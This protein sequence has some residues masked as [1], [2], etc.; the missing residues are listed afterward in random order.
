MD[1]QL[2]DVNIMINL[3]WLFARCRLTHTRLCGLILHTASCVTLHSF[4][5]SFHHTTVHVATQSKEPFRVRLAHASQK[6][7]KNSNPKPKLDS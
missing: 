5:S 3:P 7:Q 2:L 1:V 4:T 6:T